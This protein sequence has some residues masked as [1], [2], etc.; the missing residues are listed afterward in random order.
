MNGQNQTVVDAGGGGGILMEKTT[1]ETFTLL[2]DMASNN[3]KWPIKRSIAK[4]ATRVYDVDQFTALSAQIS[5]LA[6][7]FATFTT[8]EVGPKDATVMATGCYP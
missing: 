8:Q 3:H 2:E 6:N 1:E 4:K 5:A 7:Q